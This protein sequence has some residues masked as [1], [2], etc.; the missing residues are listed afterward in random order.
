MAINKL[1]R[2][3]TE[4]WQRAAGAWFA[5]FL[6]FNAYCFFWR[7]YIGGGHYQFFDSQ[8]FW[9]KEWGSLCVLSIGVVAFFNLKA[10]VKSR[11]YFYPTM[12]LM[13]IS[14]IISLRILI[15][16]DFYGYA[17]AASV[18]QL[19]PKYFIASTLVLILWHVFTVQAESTPATVRPEHTEHFEKADYIEV[20]HKG[21]AKKLPLASVVFI[22]SAGNYLEIQTVENRYLKRDTIKHLYSE[23]PSDTFCQVHRS[24]IVNV[25]Q[26]ADFNLALNKCKLTMA[27]G[28]SV[29]VSKSFKARVSD[30]LSVED[31]FITK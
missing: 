2:H 8:L 11:I 28:F 16:F 25:A 18:T 24:Y 30:L 22:K 27:A 17:L 26:I 29:P 12:L 23:L 21:V 4:P 31:S 15:D 20:N 3:L 14:L 7:H 1:W 19:F 13:S 9:L 6:L 10:R 5:F